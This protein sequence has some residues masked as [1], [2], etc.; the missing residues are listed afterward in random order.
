MDY[1]GYFAEDFF[2]IDPHWG[3]KAAPTCAH[4]RVGLSRGPFWGG[5]FTQLANQSLDFGRPTRFLND[6]VEIGSI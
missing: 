6:P 3:T 4:A 2:D 1:T 5:D